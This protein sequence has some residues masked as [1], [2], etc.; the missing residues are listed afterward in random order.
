MSSASVPPTN[1]A[2]P[3]SSQKRKVSSIEPVERENL[4]LYIVADQFDS[5]LAE[6]VYH[7][8][9]VDALLPKNMR[10]L[11]STINESADATQRSDVDGEQTTCQLCYIVKANLKKSGATKDEIKSAIAFLSPKDHE[12]DGEQASEQGRIEARSV[13]MY[14]SKKLPILKPHQAIVRVFAAVCSTNK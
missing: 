4:V 10:W 6:L 7:L 1:E 12:T 9:P 8:A 14:E 2:A 5:D 11:E 3:P 13:W